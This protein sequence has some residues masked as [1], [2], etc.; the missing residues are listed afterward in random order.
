MLPDPAQ[1][2]QGAGSLPLLLLVPSELPV[3]LIDGPC[4]DLH[5]DSPVQKMTATGLRGHCLCSL[6]A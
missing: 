6:A 3:I 1:I 5:C 4:D 2:S